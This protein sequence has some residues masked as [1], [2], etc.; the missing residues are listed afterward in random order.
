[1]TKKKSKKN[2][3]QNRKKAQQVKKNKNVGARFEG[4]ITKVINT[5]FE[6]NNIIG[7]AYR[8]PAG[9]SMNQPIDILID[10]EFVYAGIE[11]K[12]I[13]TESLSNGKIYFTKLG[14]VNKKGIHQFQHQHFFLN[15]ACRKGLIIINFRDLRQTYVIPHE[16]LYYM[17]ERGEIYITIDYIQRNYQTLRE[18]DI[19]DY[20][21]QL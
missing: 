11:C 5:Y 2:K 10:S 15:V 9:K 7:I 1:M 19:K 18:I 3:S 4:K 20:L 12:S 14:N 6:D 16:H 21:L 13:F 17:V 8:F